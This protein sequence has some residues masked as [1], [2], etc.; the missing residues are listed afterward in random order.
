MTTLNT[1]F[2]NLGRIG[3]DKSD[4]SQRNQSNTKFANYTLENHLQ[5]TN[6]NEHVQFA[7]STHAMNFKNTVSGG[8]PANAVDY[9]SLLSI[10]S[11]QQR[12]FEKLQLHPRPFATV[13][14]LGKGGANPDMES[15]L[16]HG[17]VVSDRK[18]Q[19]TIMDKSYINYD[20]Y[21]LMD[22]VKK[23]INDPSK[24]IEELALDGWRRGG[25]STREIN[26]SEN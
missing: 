7:T 6:S 20:E 8:L 2:N 19:S 23:R 22:D 9:D 5:N 14:Y 15:K 3:A 4:N 10:K 12:E 13:P 21:P 24:A 1:T 25:V 26:I 17:E 11:K 16:L 18:S